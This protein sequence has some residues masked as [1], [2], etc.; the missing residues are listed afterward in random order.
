MTW[1]INAE[2]PI[3]P[4]LHTYRALSCRDGCQP[5]SSLFLPSIIKTSDI[6]EEDST[7]ENVPHADNRLPDVFSG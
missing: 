7:V 5:K 6:A 4:C 3:T 2:H 1:F